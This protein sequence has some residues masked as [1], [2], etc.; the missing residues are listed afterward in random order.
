M[1]FYISY[2]ISY[3]ILY[4]CINLK[5]IFYKL[6]ILDKVNFHIVESHCKGS[7]FGCFNSHMKCL[8][9]SKGDYTI[10]FEDD[11]IENVEFK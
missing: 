9:K 8:E 4:F 6:G 11:C 3:F 2:L 1:I 7:R 5:K 10:I